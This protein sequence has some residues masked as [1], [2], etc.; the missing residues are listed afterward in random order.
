MAP[1]SGEYATSKEIETGYISGLTFGPKKVTYAVIDGKA[2]FEGDIVLGSVDEIR[3]FTKD[4]EMQKQ[5][6][7]GIETAVVY[8]GIGARWPN[9]LVPYEIDPNLPDQQRVVDSI[10]HWESETLMR[11]INRAE[12][13]P[14]EHP[15]YIFFTPHLEVCRSWIGMQGGRQLIELQPLCTTGSVIHEI[16]HAIGL[17]HEQSREDR[18]WYITVIFDNIKPEAVDNFNQRITNGDDVGEY[19]YCSIMHYHARAFCK[20]PCPGDTIVVKEPTFECAAT[21]GQGTTLSEGDKAAIAQLNLSLIVAYTGRGES[22]WYAKYSQQHGWEAQEKIP[23]V[24]SSVGP[25][26][27]SYKGRMFMAWKGIDGDQ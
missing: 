10:K 2:I 17:W 12:R 7:K 5:Y 1:C 11:F 14:S 16:G 18:D 22:I 3:R 21:I 24:G 6:G 23:N 19:D 25:S 27:V 9:A 26:L 13:R 4:V 20:D 8:P 15:N